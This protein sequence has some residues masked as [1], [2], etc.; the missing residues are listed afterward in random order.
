MLLRQLLW[1]GSRRS[2]HDGCELSLAIA[3]QFGVD[4]DVVTAKSACADYGGAER[5]ALL[6]GDRGKTA[7]VEFK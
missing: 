6:A 1:S 7:L 3:R 2:V 5:S 4:A